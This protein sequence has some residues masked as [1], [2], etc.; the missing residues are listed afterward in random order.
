MVVFHNGKWE[1]LK[2]GSPI[3]VVV[4]GVPSNWVMIFTISH[5]TIGHY[6]VMIGTTVC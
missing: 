6:G 4:L 2:M 3:K 1:P 5:P